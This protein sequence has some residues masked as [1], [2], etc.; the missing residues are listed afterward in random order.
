MSYCVVFVRMLVLSEKERVWLACLTRGG[1][2]TYLTVYPSC[3]KNYSLFLKWTKKKKK[4]KDV[5]LV[6][7]LWAN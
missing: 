3:R 5:L 7:E 2:E 4:K 1:F 6:D